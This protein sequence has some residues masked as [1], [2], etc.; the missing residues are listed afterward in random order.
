MSKWRDNAMQR[1]IQCM[2]MFPSRDVNTG[3]LLGNRAD[4]G[5]CMNHVSPHEPQRVRRFL[6]G[7]TSTCGRGGAPSCRARPIEWSDPWRMTIS[8]D[9]RRFLRI[10]GPRHDARPTVL[11]RR[12]NSFDFTRG[13]FRRIVCF[14]RS[15]NVLLVDRS[16]P[17]SGIARDRDALVV[18]RYQTAMHLY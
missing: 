1:E 15:L 11:L 18:A 7:A 3:E 5:R 2:S 8:V 14:R 10:R 16:S 12:R 13:R 4:R 17:S 6:R 9:D